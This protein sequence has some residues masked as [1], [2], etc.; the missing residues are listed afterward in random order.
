MEENKEILEVQE[1]ET[2]EV[3]ET[4]EAAEIQEEATV[5]NEISDSQEY[6]SALEEG[7]LPSKNEQILLLYREGKDEVEIAKTLNCGLG[8]V[9]LVLGLYKN[10]A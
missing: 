6:Y 10:E 4:V 7:A 3:V 9:K 8:E 5:I 1:T 2:V